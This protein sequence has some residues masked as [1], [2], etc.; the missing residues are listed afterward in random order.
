M[1][2]RA[3]CVE[4]FSRM[5]QTDT[6]AHWVEL[7]SAA[8]VPCGP[9]NRVSDVVNDPQVRARNMIA[10]MPH[11]DVPD[12]RVPASPIKLNETPA[13]IRRPPPGLGQDNDEILSE[14]GF[15]P[16]NISDLRR[17]GS[18]RRLEPPARI[19]QQ[20]KQQAGTTFGITQENQ[21]RP[22]F[23]YPPW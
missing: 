2:H 8:G 21:A 20:I 6:V 16:D 9:I 22:Y 15:D 18:H 1:A 10:D 7:I 17:R 19:T 3:E 14:L 5:F 11:P 12:L 4:I 13:E 23:R